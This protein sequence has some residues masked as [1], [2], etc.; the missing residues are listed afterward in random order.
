MEYKRKLKCSNN[1]LVH[2][3]TAINNICVEGRYEKI[4]RKTKQKNT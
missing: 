3:K 4:K 1:S 2:N